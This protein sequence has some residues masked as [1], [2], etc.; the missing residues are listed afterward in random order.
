MGKFE[1]QK[2]RLLES[3]FRSQTD[4]IQ[5]LTAK[6]RNNISRI[7]HIIK[8]LTFHRLNHHKSSK[9]DK[10][11][12]LDKMSHIYKCG[13]VFYFTLFSFMFSG[14]LSLVLINYYIKNWK[15]ILPTPNF[16]IELVIGISVLCLFAF[17]IGLFG[18]HRR[19]VLLLFIFIVVSV[20]ILVTHIGFVLYIFSCSTELLEDSINVMNKI[21]SNYSTN[22]DSTELVLLNHKLRCCNLSIDHLPSSCCPLTIQV[23]DQSSKYPQDCV[24]ALHTM[25]IFIESF[26]TSIYIIISLFMVIC[27]SQANNMVSFIEKNNHRLLNNR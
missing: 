26:I 2:I 11:T 4:V 24:L 16:F 23:C 10:I 9:I 15:L 12:N 27:V 13:K 6:E 1:E 20:I 7:N 22:A 3:S 18:Y 19:W 8:K 21:Y 25:W 5:V 14:V 17:F